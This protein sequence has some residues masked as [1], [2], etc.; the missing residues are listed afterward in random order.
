MTDRY[1]GPTLKKRLG[2]YLPGRTLEE[3]TRIADEM[4]SGKF[5]LPEESAI[6]PIMATG[7]VVPLG[8]KLAEL[9]RLRNNE[10]IAALVAQKLSGQAVHNEPDTPILPIEQAPWQLSRPNKR[11]RD[12]IIWEM[13]RNNETWE[14]IANE[15]EKR[16]LGSGVNT[17]KENYKRMEKESTKNKIPVVFR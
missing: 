13:R 10:E 1:D 2:E 6:I 11:E 16:D 15:I 8:I 9:E 7:S 5:D 14:R 3:F 12:K 17:V 4:N